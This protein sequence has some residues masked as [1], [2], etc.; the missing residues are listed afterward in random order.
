MDALNLKHSPRLH[1][2]RL[3]NTCTMDCIVAHAV[4][5]LVNMKPIKEGIVTCRE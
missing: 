4:Q 3:T 5:V 1:L 2:R